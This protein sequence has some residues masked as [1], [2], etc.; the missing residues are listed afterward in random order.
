MACGPLRFARLFAVLAVLIMLAVPAGA[1]AAQSGSG[2]SPVIPPFGK[3][4]DLLS[5]KWWQYVLGQ[6]A[7]S[8]PLTDPTGERCRAGQS[9]L[10]FF[11]VGTFGSGQVTRDQCSVPAG[12]LLFF[13]L[14]NG[15]DVHTPGDG[16]DTPE[17]VWNDF[18]VTLGWRV[19]A[20][21]ASVDGVPVR[22]LDP[23]TSP[24]RACAAPVSGCARPFSLRLPTG[25]LFDIPAGTYAPAVADGF[26]LLLAPLRPGVHTI[27]F[28]GEGNLGGPFTQDVTYR[29]RVLPRP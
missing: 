22:N 9:G 1:T 11:L 26:Y 14:V 27:T 20:L 7:S 4:Y 17:L 16:L 2:P 5:V 28:G 6:P 25:N 23:A 21:H 13:P 29:L 3:V 18:L 8:N 10:V 15:F 12:R 19:N 24:Y